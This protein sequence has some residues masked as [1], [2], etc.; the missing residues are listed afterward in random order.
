MTRPV[1]IIM[2]KAAVTLKKDK[3]KLAAESKEELT[4]LSGAGLLSDNVE[5]R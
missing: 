5:S 2:S 1:S 4:T 3:N